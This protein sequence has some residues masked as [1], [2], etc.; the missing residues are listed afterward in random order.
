[1]D[2]KF[3]KV[4][5]RRL[6]DRHRMCRFIDGL[7]KSGLLWRERL[8]LGSEGVSNEI[9]S[10]AGVVRSDEYSLGEGFDV[11]GGGGFFLSPE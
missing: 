4:I 3:R 1:M 10:V 7:W 11:V 8:M 5:L 2:S 6:T 9:K